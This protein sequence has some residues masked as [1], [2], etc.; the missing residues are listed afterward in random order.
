MLMEVAVCGNVASLT[1]AFD[2]FECELDVGET[3]EFVGVESPL[4]L[5][6]HDSLRPM[7]VG[8]VRS[9]GSP[10]NATGKAS[11]SSCSYPL[12]KSTLAG[13]VEENISCIVANLM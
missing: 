1:N 10:G 11:G 4:R 13:R 7:D 9:I 12:K 6:S 8:F 2:G 5:R 3:T